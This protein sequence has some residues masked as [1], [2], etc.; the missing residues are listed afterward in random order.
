MRGKNNKSVSLLSNIVCV[1][2]TKYQEYSEC[3]PIPFI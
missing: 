2:F 1:Y 3:Y